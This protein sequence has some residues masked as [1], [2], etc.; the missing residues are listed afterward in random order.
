MIKRFRTL[1]GGEW[2]GDHLPVSEVVNPF[3]NIPVAIVP[4]VGREEVYR[5]ITEARIASEVMAAMPAYRR[6]EILE[7]TSRL[8]I[9]D[10]D[11]IA[12]IITL[13]AGKAWKYA[14]AETAR[15]AETFRFAAHEA[16]AAHGGL[17]SMD[18]SPVSAGRFGYYLRTPAGVIGAISPFNF[19]L[20]LVAHK[21]A[22]AI[23]AGNTVV[24]KPA[25]KTPLSAIKLAELLVEAGIPR[26][27]ISVVIGGTE[28]G[29]AL[30]ADDRL[31]MI[32]FTGSPAVGR[33]IKARA[34][35]K[36]VALE[37]GANSPTIIDTDSDLDFAVARCV[38]GSFA[39][40]GQICV[41]VQRIYVHHSIYEVFL[42]RFVTAVRE[43]KVGDP[44]DPDTDVGPMISRA[45]LEQALAWIS[46][47]RSAGAKVETGGEAVGNCLL[48][49]VLSGVKRDMKVICAE[50]FAP[51]VSIMPFDDFDEALDMADDSPFGLQAGVFTRDI[52]K[53]FR[54]VRKL[55]MGGV[56]INDVPTFRVDHMPYGGVKESGLGR[57]GV[58]Y[59]MEEM[60][61]IKMVCFNFT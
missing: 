37:L 46:E 18:A 13:E 22:P 28:V 14:V 24:L 10:R 25:P 51:V 4:I 35:L 58:R 60:S 5:A 59:A 27:A 32:S 1:I 12:E 3:N 40:S 34:G 7:K 21:V 9:R 17:V 61:T 47:A 16:L 41:S 50:V 8:I 6:S 52:H 57:E 43:L 30:V 31:A 56:I 42:K 48:P 38:Y 2:I 23:A 39:N 29:E 20:N 54:A 15:S 45:V 11:E 36:R 55:H 26:G 44:L 33:Q 49:T 53:A 19:P